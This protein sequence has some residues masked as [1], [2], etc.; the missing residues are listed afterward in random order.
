MTKRGRPR[1]FDRTAALEKAM[2]LFWNQGFDCTSMPDLVREMKINSPSIYAAFGSKEKLFLEAVEHYAE[3]EKEPIWGKF[4]GNVSAFDAICSMLVASAN[5]FTRSDKP[6]GCLVILGALTAEGGNQSVRA[7]LQTRRAVC[8]KL[9]EGRL[10]RAIEEGEL[11]AEIDTQGLATFFL[12]VQQGMSVQARDGSSR[13]A[14]L[15]AAE[16]AMAGWDQLRCS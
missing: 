16:F 1:N 12:S 2:Y 15:A 5:A 10:K 11:R 4:E 9:I 13:E 8:L 7:E 3:A 14:L 6:N